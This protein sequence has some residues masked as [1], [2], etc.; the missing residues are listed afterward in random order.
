[1]YSSYSLSS[2]NKCGPEKSFPRTTVYAKILTAQYN[3]SERNIWWP[4]NRKYDAKR[5][6]LRPYFLISKLQ[7]VALKRFLT[8]K[9][10]IFLRGPKLILKDINVVTP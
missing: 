3:L 8:E 10:I 2:D 5:M 6:L 4:L 9:C 7:I 1:M